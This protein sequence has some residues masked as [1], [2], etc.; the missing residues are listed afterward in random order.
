MNLRHRRGPEHP[1][2]TGRTISVRG[3]VRVRCDGH[4]R[5]DRN[6]FVLEHILVVEQVLGRYL[7]ACHPIHHVNENRQDNRPSNLVVCQ[8]NAYHRL[9]HVRLK[10]R[11][12]CGNPNYRQCLFCKAWD[13]PLC[14]NER[15][16]STWE[17][18]QC[19]REY[20][21]ARRLRRKLEIVD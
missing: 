10:A 5:A 20:Q 3:Y 21:K 9:L 6:G 15:G 7:E 4:P 12:A 16:Q 1:L 18:V 8:D 2:F 19:R 17:H 13:D 14:L 11:E